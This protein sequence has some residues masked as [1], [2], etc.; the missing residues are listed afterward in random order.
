[1]SNRLSTENLEKIIDRVAADP[2]KASE[3]KREILKMVTAREPAPSY[4]HRV[5]RPIA[6]IDDDLFDNM[7]V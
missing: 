4:G 2:R 7:P 3:A 1:M 5:R 6:E